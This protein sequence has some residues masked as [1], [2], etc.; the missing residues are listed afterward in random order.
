VVDRV[1]A[2]VPDPDPQAAELL[3]PELGDDRAQAVVAARTA[4][5]AEPELSERQREVVDHHEEVAERRVLAG[6][7]LADREARLVHVR[8]RLDEREVEPAV[9]AEHDVRRVAPAALTAPARALGDPIHHEPA[10]V[11]AGAGVLGTRVAE[12]HDDLHETLRDSRTGPAPRC[13]GTVG[14]LSRW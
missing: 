13:R 6:E 2:G 7:H 8:Q 12:P 3:G 14:G 9:A 5:L 1:A 11:V 10:D 4:T